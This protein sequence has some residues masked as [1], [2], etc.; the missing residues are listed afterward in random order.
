MLGNLFDAKRQQSLDSLLG[1]WG[2]IKSKYSGGGDAKKVGSLLGGGAFVPPSVS[3][4][5]GSEDPKKG[6][7]FKTQAEIELANK[8]AR[9]FAKS[10]GYE[11]WQN[12]YVGRKIGD[13]VPKYIDEAT[14]KEFIPMPS[15]QKL[16]KLPNDIKLSDI[17]SEAGL[18]W[19]EDPQTGDVIDVDPSVVND[20]RFRKDKKIV[21][22][23][24]ATRRSITQ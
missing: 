2:G 20:P 12:T 9:E 19:Y 15:K 1:L 14:G 7:V 17:K 10:H 18:Y 11:D 21:E 4:L 22:Q 6:K 3:S 16:M 5:L 24:L 23:D 13:P 8:Q